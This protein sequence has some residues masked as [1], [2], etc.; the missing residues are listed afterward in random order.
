MLPAR[1]R[2]PAGDPDFQGALDA[3]PVGRGDLSTTLRID[4]REPAVQPRRRDA[5]QSRAD[6]LVA[7]RHFRK[8]GE[9]RAQIKERAA[10]EDRPPPAPGDLLARQRREAR[11]VGGVELLVRVDDVEEMVRHALAIR[12]R[13]LRAADVEVAVDLDGV[14]VDDLAM[15]RLGQADG[16]VGFADTCWTGDDDQC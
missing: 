13:R 5:A 11:V 9:E 16:E 10:D 12:R 8:P 3:V 1:D 7:P 6:L 4:F 14:V 2:P 15:E